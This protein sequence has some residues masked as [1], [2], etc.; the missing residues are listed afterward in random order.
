MQIILQ[1]STSLIPNPIIF[2]T[3]LHYISLPPLHVGGLV[4]ESLPVIIVRL[5][6]YI[7]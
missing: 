2:N 1:P 6:T 4:A 7:L 3:F 5:V